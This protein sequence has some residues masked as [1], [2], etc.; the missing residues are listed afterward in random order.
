MRPKT[1]AREAVEVLIT[2]LRMLKSFSSILFFPVTIKM[3]RP[4]VIEK[5]K[6]KGDGKA[7]AAHGK[8]VEG[9]KAKNSLEKSITTRSA[10]KVLELGIFVD[11][12]AVDLFMPYLGHKEYA[13]LRE[14]V[15]AFVNGVRSFTTFARHL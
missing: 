3:E 7:K 1:K 11:Q 2:L 15:L 6:G 4:K 14:L 5:R 8:S 10:N 12:A 9:G 13:K